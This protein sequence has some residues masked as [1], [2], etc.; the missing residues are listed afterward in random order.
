M[1]TFPHPIERR[2]FGRRQSQAHATISA[3]GRPSIPCIM[4]DVSDGGALLE[5][6]NPHWLPCRFR[7]VIQANGFEAECEIVHRT[8]HA[9]GV[10][11]AASTS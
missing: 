7:L 5:V 4:R 3:R 1:G 9:V 10:R 11:F 2:Q 8:E 6:P